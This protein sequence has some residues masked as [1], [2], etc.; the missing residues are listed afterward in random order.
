[1]RKML[2]TYGLPVLKKIQAFLS[3]S[4]SIIT[5]ACL[6]WSEQSVLCLLGKYMS[7]LPVVERRLGN[8]ECAVK[9]Y[10]HSYV[11]VGS[12]AAFSFSFLLHWQ[13]HLG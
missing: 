3:L 7:L 4:F 2:L 1:M 10:N 13:S 5:R 11:G 8:L 12:Q 6:F 9:F